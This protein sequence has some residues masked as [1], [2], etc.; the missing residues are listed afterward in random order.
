MSYITSV[1]HLDLYLLTLQSLLQDDYHIGSIFPC[2]LRLKICT[3]ETKWLNL[4]MREL[5]DSPK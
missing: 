3:C 4:L 5:K 2:L 1:Q